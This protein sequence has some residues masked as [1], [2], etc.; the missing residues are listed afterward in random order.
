M[1]FLDGLLN[2]L[3]L[4]QGRGNVQAE[5]KTV[6]WQRNS[7]F[8]RSVFYMGGLTEEADVAIRILVKPPDIL[9]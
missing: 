8:L 4:F 1:F 7:V 2:E 9:Q 6:S 3:L 5:I